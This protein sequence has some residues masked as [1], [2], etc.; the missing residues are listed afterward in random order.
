MAYTPKAANAFKVI[1]EQNYTRC[2]SCSPA[3]DFNLDTRPG[4]NNDWFIE[5]MKEELGL[6]IYRSIYDAWRQRDKSHFTQ[7]SLPSQERKLR[8][9]L[10]IPQATANHYRDINTYI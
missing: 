7:T 4:K 1:K 5:F 2:P 10:L 3:G 6:A 9:L 8:Y